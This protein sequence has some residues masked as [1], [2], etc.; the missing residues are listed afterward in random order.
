METES[1]V[2]IVLAVFSS[3]GFWTLIN[4]CLENR[5]TEKSAEKRAL[6]GLLHDRVYSLGNY[7]ISQGKITTSEYD[8]FMYIY[9][10]YEELKGNGTGQ[11]IKE[12]VDDLPMVN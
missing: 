12:A 9:K 5:K 10:P 1:I 8:N 4:N 6:L 7:Y 3:T 11:K 2:A